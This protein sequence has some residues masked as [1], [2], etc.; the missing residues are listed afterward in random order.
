MPSGHE[1]PSSERRAAM[2]YLDR[3]WVNSNGSGSFQE[4]LY[5]LSREARLA[6]QAHQAAISYVPDGD[7]Q[8]AIHTHSFSDKYEQYNSYDVMPTGEGIWGLVVQTRRGVCMT[9]A[10]LQAH[11][12]AVESGID[13]RGGERSLRLSL[14]GGS[15]LCEGRRDLSPRPHPR[16]KVIVRWCAPARP[17]F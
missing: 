9:D 5:A 17:E 3:A 1:A 13:P 11:P 15:G 12:Q 7:F 2:V 16:N 6:V 8:A 14:A 10:E 4:A